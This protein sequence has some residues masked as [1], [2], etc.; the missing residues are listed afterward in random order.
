MWKLIQNGKF[1]N[2]INNRETKLF[3]QRDLL[4]EI[5]YGI[6]NKLKRL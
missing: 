4:M 1:M 3:S 6:F 5:P 2:F